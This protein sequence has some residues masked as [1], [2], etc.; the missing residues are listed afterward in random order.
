MN[1]HT[2]VGSQG[3]LRLGKAPLVRVLCQ[4][5]W[6]TFS[7]FDPEQVIHQMGID[8]ADKYPVSSRGQEYQVVL[9]PDGIEQ[10]TGESLYR[11]SSAD[12]T[13]NIT[14]AKTFVSLETT[15]YAGHLDFIQRLGEI[16]KALTSAFKIPTWLRIGYRYT[17]RISG[18]KDLSQLSTYFNYPSVLG[19][20]GW[21]P[22]G[23][24]LLQ[25]ITESVYKKDEATVLVRSASLAPGATVDPTLEPV[26]EPSWIL[27]LDASFDVEPGFPLQSADITSKAEMLSEACYGLFDGLVSKQFVERFK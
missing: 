7:T 20:E 25:S 26:D 10:G 18:D 14:L 11:L 4:I 19:G 5:R 21:K 3:H 22:E 12:G 6:Q 16:T 1:A 13:W 9:T 17:N 27:D 24:D 15:K 8:L 2:A 23:T